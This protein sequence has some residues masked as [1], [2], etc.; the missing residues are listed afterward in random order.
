MGKI[1]WCAAMERLTNLPKIARI[2]VKPFAALQKDPLLQMAYYH[3]QF[4][5]LVLQ[6]IITATRVEVD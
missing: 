4:A 6:G 1:L 3:R 5:G 2:V